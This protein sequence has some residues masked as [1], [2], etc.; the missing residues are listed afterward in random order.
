MAIQE[1]KTH[2]KKGNYIIIDNSVSIRMKLKD[3]LKNRKNLI[4]HTLKG[5]LKFIRVRDT[6]SNEIKGDRVIRRKLDGQIIIIEQNS[7]VYRKYSDSK[8]FERVKKGHFTLELLYN[9]NKVHFLDNCITKERY[10]KGE[11]L[12]YSNHSAQN[13]VFD[14]VINNYYDSIINNNIEE[15]PARIDTE[16]FFIE[17]NKTLYPQEL[18]SFMFENK[19]KVKELFRQLKWTWSHGDLTPQNI[20]YNKREYIV[21][22]GERCEILPVFYDIANLM[23]NYLLMANNENCYINYF[24]GKYDSLL[25]SIIGIDEVNNYRKVVLI[26]MMVLKG[27]IAWDAEIKRD[28]AELMTKRWKSISKFLID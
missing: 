11:P 17:L 3:I 13:I 7:W 9:I 26:V 2:L 15:F 6:A 19:E 1:I 14:N 20:L 8:Q 18:K 24:R 12:T 4:L 28:N 5:S 22:D 23:N 21:M 16:Q 27:T 25:K 10:I